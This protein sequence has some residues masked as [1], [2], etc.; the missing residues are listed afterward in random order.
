MLIQ[1]FID[2]H[3]KHNISTNMSLTNVCLYKTITGYAPAA[4]FTSCDWCTE[5]SCQ[6]YKLWLVHRMQLPVLQAVIGAPNPAAGFTSCDWCTES[7]C[8]FY[9]LWLVHRM[10]LSVLQAVIGAPNPA[11]G[12][13]KQWLVYVETLI[14]C[15]W[16]TSVYKILQTK[17]TG[18]LYEIHAC[19]INFSILNMT[20]ANKFCQLDI[21]SFQKEKNC[22][23]L[24]LK[25]IYLLWCYDLISWRDNVH[26]ET[27]TKSWN[28]WL[29]SL[30]CAIQLYI[31]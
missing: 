13:Y 9:K 16:C 27:L 6:F 21:N 30:I 10:Q 14:L 15:L 4:G 24:L 19:C 22:L 29:K 11:A 18:L 20:N 5:S 8:Q 1:M 7:S 31:T 12:F 17:F 26:I 25:L 28:S 3:H 2:E 23:V